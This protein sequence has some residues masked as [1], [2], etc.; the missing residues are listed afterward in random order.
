[1]NYG[2]K[3]EVIKIMYQCKLHSIKFNCTEYDIPILGNVRP[4]ALIQS[5]DI[6]VEISILNLN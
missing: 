1:M 6:F 5:F 2:S 3:A 4:W